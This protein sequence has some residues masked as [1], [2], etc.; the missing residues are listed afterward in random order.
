MGRPPGRVGVLYAAG[1]NGTTPHFRAG[2]VM[3]LVTLALFAA[4][5]AGLA[6]AADEKKDDK[7]PAAAG[8]IDWGEYVDYT[9]AAGTV[10]KLGEAGFTLKV[11]QLYASGSSRRPRLRVRA[12][13]IDLTFHDAGLVRWAKPPPRPDAKGKK[14]PYSEAELKALKQPAGA[15]GYAADRA[16]LQARMAVTVVVMRPKNIPADGLTEQDYR[17][18]YVVLLGDPAAK[19][20]KDKKKDDKKPD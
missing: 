2:A 9:E 1:Y 20:D 18:K 15:P 19:E 17:V 6:H 12:E 3:K 4:A 13:T 16:D 11:S 10:A 14:V 5:A 8:K 7:K